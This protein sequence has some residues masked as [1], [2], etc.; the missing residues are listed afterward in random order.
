[1]SVMYSMMHVVGGDPLWV[2]CGFRRV[3]VVHPVANL[4]AVFCVIC[5]LSDA[6]SDH[7]V[8][9]YSSMGFASC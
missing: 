2:V 3:D 4:S 1:M 8:E 9:T 7:M 6:S 5:S